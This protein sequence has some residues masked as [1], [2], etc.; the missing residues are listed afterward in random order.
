MKSPLAENK[1]QAINEIKPIK[2]LNCRAAKGKEAT[3]K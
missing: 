1:V 3:I 2:S